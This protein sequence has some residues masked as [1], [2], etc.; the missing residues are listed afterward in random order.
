MFWEEEK[1]DKSSKQK[2]TTDKNI[3]TQVYNCH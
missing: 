1:T 3:Q 2:M